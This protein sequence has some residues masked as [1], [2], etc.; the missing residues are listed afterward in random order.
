MEISYA[1]TTGRQNHRPSV[2]LVMDTS[3]SNIIL[4]ISQI[5][6]DLLKGCP[7][8][9]RTKPNSVR[10]TVPPKTL[11]NIHGVVGSRSL[12]QQHPT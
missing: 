12:S 3:M 4:I 6:A 1:A 10:N 9:R 2:L 8:P 7:N 5:W 11:W